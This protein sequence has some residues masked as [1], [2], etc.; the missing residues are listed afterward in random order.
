ML[1]FSKL[2]SSSLA[3]KKYNFFCQ[4]QDRHFQPVFIFQSKEA[5]PC[6][7]RICFGWTSLHFKTYQEAM[8]YCKNHGFSA[9]NGEPLLDPGGD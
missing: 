3:N 1:D 7:W 6:N 5:S 4:L 2:K 8:E 9:P